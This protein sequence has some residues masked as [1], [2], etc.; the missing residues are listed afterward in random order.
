MPRLNSIQ[1]SIF[2]HVNH[3]SDRSAEVAKQAVRLEPSLKT[4]SDRADLPESNLLN[5]L[6]SDL[7]DDDP[8][9]ED[10]AGEDPAG[11]DL[12][13]DEELLGEAH[14]TPKTDS[15][16]QAFAEEAEDGA[17]LDESSLNTVLEILTT[18]ATAEEL[19]I[20]EA[21]TAAQKRQ[22][23]SHTP[24]T[25]KIKLKQIRQADITSATSLEGWQTLEEA[26]GDRNQPLLNVGDWVVLLAKPKLTTAELVAIWEVVEVHEASARI[27]SHLGIRNYP[28]S[29]MMP[30][31][32][33]ISTSA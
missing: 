22:V 19:T 33:P 1:P 10:L 20:L 3:E 12:L 32:K 25:I 4:E 31:P 23:W 11:E 26:N 2:H 14:L 6:N 17:L 30:Y 9:F 24:D 7:V 8:D 18:I 28:M 21:L 27:K 29:W 5:L 15:F 13:G 16:I